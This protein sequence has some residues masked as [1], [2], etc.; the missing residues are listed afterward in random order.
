MTLKVST[1]KVTNF[2]KHIILLDIKYSEHSTARF[3]AIRSGG[4]SIVIG[5][6][7]C[8]RIKRNNQEE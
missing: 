7:L 2:R 1:R 3:T 4:F 8:R 6:R 5:G